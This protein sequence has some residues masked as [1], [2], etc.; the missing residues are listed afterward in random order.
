MRDRYFYFYYMRVLGDATLAF[1]TAHGVTLHVSGTHKLHVTALEEDMIRVRLDHARGRAV[2]NSWMVAPGGKAPYEGRDKE[3]LSGFALPRV[4][5]DEVDGV[6]LVAT[7]RLRVHV[8][9]GVAP[10][11]LRWEWYDAAAGEWRLLFADRQ[12]GAYYVGRRDERLSHFVRRRRGDRFFGLGEKAGALE[13]SGRRFRMDCTDAMG[14]DAEASDPLY[15]FWP[16]YIAKPAVSAGEGACASAAYG[17]FYDN[18]ANCAVDLGC[19]YDNYH[20]LFS[21][22]EASCGDL[23]YTVLLGPSVLAVTR[24]FAWLC[25]GHTLPPLWSV[26]YSGSTMSY[27]DAP[28]AQERMRAPSRSRHASA[29]H[30]TSPLS[31][32][33]RMRLFL[34]L[35]A[36]HEIPCSSFQMSSGYT[37]IGT[38]RYVFHWN[39]DKFPEPAAFAAEFAAAGVHLAANI[40]PC[41]LTDHPRYAECRDAG[42]F[43][44]DSLIWDSALGTRDSGDNS[45]DNSEERDSA[46]GTRDSTVARAPEPAGEPESEA[47]AAATAATAAEAAALKILARA[48][49]VIDLDAF[50]QIVHALSLVAAVGSEGGGTDGAAGALPPPPPPPPVPE[51]SMFWEAVGSHLDFTNPATAAWW[52]TQVRE[53]LLSLGIGS[54]WNDNNEWRVEDEGA[55]CHGFGNPTPLRLIRPVQV[56]MTLIGFDGL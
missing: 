20:G 19:T 45:G 10:L 6:L 17:L 42:L 8:P 38:K 3:D 39:R 53:Q 1:S 37:S 24:R 15:K 21:S 40:K 36:K 23:E 34:E 28:N 12:T 51:T 33:E 56:P 14:Y 13:R 2:R 50:K 4:S 41:L 25:G 11:A 48:P 32:Q 55:L 54:T 22:Y 29:H 18:P 52:R 9:L 16:F 7:S 31:P 47:A 27:T 49:P 43:L 35:C 26:G 46:L 30:G 5:I 44:R